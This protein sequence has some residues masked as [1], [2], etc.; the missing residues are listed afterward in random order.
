MQAYLQENQ[1]YTNWNGMS[2]QPLPTSQAREG[3]IIVP[4]YFNTKP[5]A[6]VTSFVTNLPQS[7]YIS[8]DDIMVIGKQ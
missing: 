3:I 6:R 5:N 1:H 4:N 8:P 7:V 2:Q